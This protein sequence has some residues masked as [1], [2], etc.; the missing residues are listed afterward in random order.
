M[1]ELYD[2]PQLEEIKIAPMRSLLQENGSTGGTTPTI[3]PG[4]VD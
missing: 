2:T 4:G 1:K 3:P